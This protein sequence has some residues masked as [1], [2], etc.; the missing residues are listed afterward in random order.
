MARDA[1]NGEG[2][3]FTVLVWR[4]ADGRGRERLLATLHGDAGSLERVAGLF[5]SRAEIAAALAT[6]GA[7]TWQW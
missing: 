6:T 2:G 4:V 5:A 7:F 3:F 1:E